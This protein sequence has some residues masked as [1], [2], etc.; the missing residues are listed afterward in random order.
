MVPTFV[1][2]ILGDLFK[3]PRLRVA[4]VRREHLVG[5]QVM[6]I[7]TMA[8]ARKGP[9]RVRKLVQARMGIQIW[10]IASPGSVRNQW[11]AFV[12]RDGPPTQGTLD[13]PRVTLDSP[14]V[15]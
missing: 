8:D 9:S 11:L 14:R 13:S 5:L 6:F 1:R 2:M 10:L 7:R 15:H 4:V 3:I 12:A